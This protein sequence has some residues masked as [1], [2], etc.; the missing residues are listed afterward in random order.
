M[1]KKRNI[2][3]RNQ[4]VKLLSDNTDTKSS[5]LMTFKEFKKQ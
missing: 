3:I 1:K 5:K 2:F 4:S